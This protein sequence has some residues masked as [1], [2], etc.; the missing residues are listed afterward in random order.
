MISIDFTIRV[1]KFANV[2]F[3]TTGISGT[4]T[5]HVALKMNRDINNE[6]FIACSNGASF[7]VVTKVVQ[8]I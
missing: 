7:L 6:P 1:G 4:E 5:L 8:Y 2:V 3:T